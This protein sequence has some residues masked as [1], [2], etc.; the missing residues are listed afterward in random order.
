MLGYTGK[1]AYIDLSAKKV[2]IKPTPL[3]LAEKFIGG[4]GL[5]ARLLYEHLKPEIEPLAP[6]AY[7]AV[8]AGP[9]TGT[10]L[11][12]SSR[13]A[14]CGR[15]PLTGFWG[16]ATSGGKFGAYLKKAGFDGLIITGKAADMVYLE[17]KNG[18][19][20]IKPG[21]NLKGLDTYELQDELKKVYSG[22]ISIAGIGVAGENLMP[23]A[24]V[25]NDHGRAAGR[26]GFGAVFGSKN[27]KAI[28]VEGQGEVPVAAKEPLHA[29]A[30]E[31]TFLY[32]KEA[33]LFT[34]YGTLAYLDI[35]YY[36][37]DAPV[38][39]FT[40]GLFPID[41][42]NA[43]RFREEYA[44]HPKACWG[45]PIACGREL[46]FKGRIVDGP[47]YETAVAFGPLVEN[48]DL[49]TIVEANDIANR[50]G[51]DTISAGVT[52][53][54]LMYLKEENLLPDNLK[55]E[56]PD[57]GDAEGIIS[58]L[59]LT[60]EKRG[61]GKLIGQGVVKTL[62]ELGLSQEYAAAVRKLEIPMHEP[63]AFTGQALSYATGPRGAC[64]QRGDFFEVDLGIIKDEDLGIVPGPRNSIEGRVDLVA[65]FQSLRELDNCLVKCNFTFTPLKA[66]IGALSFITGVP[67]SPEKVLA[68][69]NNS[70]TIKRAIAFNLGSSPADDKLPGHV[71]KPL[72]EGGAFGNVPEIEKY[73]PEF[74][75]LRGWN[76]D[77]TIP[78]EYL[79]E[80]LRD[81]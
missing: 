48:F 13:F 38:K 18:N 71:K 45:C 19:V 59:K 54:L 27:L 10:A 43:K 79:A 21:N 50:Y 15:S 44:I 33:E 78:D 30:R 4:S 55:A 28:V 35:G 56:V 24:A 46:K 37:G 51:F 73:L 49:D 9:V 61:I 25:I 2:E 5:A 3:K 31:L 80:L 69:A 74:Y 75:Q 52:L 17:V 81:D 1:I 70:L 32:K 65:K 12:G 22:N 62:E 57:F 68:A 39:Y 72:A 11:P 63:R 60:G 76:L 14:V 6:E 40:R 23:M 7:V 26:M 20:E 67:W 36:F 64:H 42:V 34:Q 66:V 47:E 29:L 41:K 8:M 77:G 53:A 16:E 58:A